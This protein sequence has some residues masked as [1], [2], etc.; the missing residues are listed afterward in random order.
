MEDRNPMKKILLAAVLAASTL[1]VS[2]APA[3]ATDGT[4]S[5]G[6]P[7]ISGKD[8]GK[9]G[10]SGVLQGP[11]DT[12]W[13]GPSV[14]DPYDRVLW[15]GA[16]QMVVPGLVQCSPHAPTTSHFTVRFYMWAQAIREWVPYGS[17]EVYDTPTTYHHVYKVLP[18]TRGKYK[19]KVFLHACYGNCIDKTA[20]SHEVNIDCLV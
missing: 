8:W 5:G 15:S 19:G 6:P 2:A 12:I 11:D 9:G 17:E 10:Q 4:Q 16:I 7:T 14:G 18:C 13:C 20:W 3:Q 1:A